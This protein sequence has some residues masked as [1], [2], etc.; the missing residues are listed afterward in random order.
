[1]NCRPCQWPAGGIGL[2]SQ[3]PGASP[4]PA[5]AGGPEIPATR[6][7][8]AAEPQPQPRSHESRRPGQAASPGHLVSG[9][10][11][12]HSDSPVAPADGGD[13]SST[14]R[15]RAG[16][17][18]LV[19][20]QCPGPVAHFK[21]LFSVATLYHSFSVSIMIMIIMIRCGRP[22][23]PGGRPTVTSQACY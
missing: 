12:G 6:P 3:A 18:L 22:A 11:P 20:C 5:L 17:P 4:P 7:G 14:S 23:G 19:R 15:R 2:G 10:G 21:F 13:P 16:V 9:P 1:M 8:L